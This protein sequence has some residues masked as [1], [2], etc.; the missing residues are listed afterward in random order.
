MLCL[1]VYSSSSTSNGLPDLLTIVFNTVLL[2]LSSVF[3]ESSKKKQNKQTKK[4]RFEKNLGT[5]NPPEWKFE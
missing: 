5:L 1:C 3:K 2:S 4:T